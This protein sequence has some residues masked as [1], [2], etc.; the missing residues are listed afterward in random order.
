MTD[1]Q[2]T[3]T[4]ETVRGT[5]PTSRTQMAVTAE[6]R[7][8]RGATGARARRRRSNRF[9]RWSDVRCG[10][11]FTKRSRAEETAKRSQRRPC[12]YTC[13]PRRYGFLCATKP[14]R[15]IFNIIIIIINFLGIRRRRAAAAAAVSSACAAAVRII[16][17]TRSRGSVGVCAHAARVKCAFTYHRNVPPPSA[18]ATPYDKGHIIIIVIM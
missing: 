3:K 18:R 1:A 13:G 11:P 6:T 17:T 5:G 2:C 10:L 4:H 7:R 14:F 9:R 8:R 16:R 12:P 15:T